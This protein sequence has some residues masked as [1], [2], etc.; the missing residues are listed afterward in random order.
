MA[1]YF[2]RGG[3]TMNQR[4]I[5]LFASVL[6]V[7]LALFGSAM[8]GPLEDGE[9]AYHRGDYADAMRLLRPLAEQGDISAQ[10][11]LGAMYFFGEGVPQDTKQCVMWYRK[12]A[13]QGNANAQT[14]LGLMYAYGIGTPKDGAQALFWYRKAAEQGDAS[15]KFTL[16]LMYVDG[17]GVP[18]SYITAHMWFNLAA[19]GAG[20]TELHSQAAKSRDGAAAKMTPAQIAEAQRLASE[21]VQSHPSTR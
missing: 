14:K 2:A 6:L 21:W 5:T 12:A 8:A 3:R 17:A 20:N 4:L 11:Q 13:E 1:A 16:G 10:F 7:E 18:Q 15:A 9:A 19:S